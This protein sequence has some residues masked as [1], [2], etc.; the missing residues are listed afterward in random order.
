MAVVGLVLDV[1]GL[2]RYAPGSRGYTHTMLQVPGNLVLVVL[3]VLTRRGLPWA[4]HAALVVWLVDAYVG[5]VIWRGSIPLLIQLFAAVL[6]FKP[7][8]TPRK[9]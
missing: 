5:W 9:T 1:A 2:F 7:V 4:L 8:I 3:A 6:V